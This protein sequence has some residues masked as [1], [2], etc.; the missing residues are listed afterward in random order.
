MPTSILSWING[1]SQNV[2]KI[3]GLSLYNLIIFDG[4]KKGLGDHKGPFSHDVSYF[5]PPCFVIDQLPDSVII[6]LQ[7]LWN[8]T[9]S[10]LLELGSWNL[11]KMFP[12]EYSLNPMYTF[13]IACLVSK[14]WRFKVEMEGIQGVGVRMERACYQEGFPVYFYSFKYV[15]S[16]F[17]YVRWGW[18]KS[19]TLQSGKN[20]MFKL[21][22]ETNASLNLGRKWKMSINF[23]LH[24][25]MY[26]ATKCF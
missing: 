5:L 14:L 3:I 11:T 23:F 6:F 19:F 12:N 7:N 15:S 22:K 13:E 24:K 10:T 9:L 17:K 16:V 8:S 4:L 21:F 2:F 20:T 18:R 1:A 26:I 25:N